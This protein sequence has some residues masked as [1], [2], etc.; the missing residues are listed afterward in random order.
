[1]LIDDKPFP[2][3]SRPHLLHL[4]KYY[5]MIGQTNHFYRMLLALCLM[6]L[7]LKSESGLFSWLTAGV[8]SF[9]PYHCVSLG[10]G[11]GGCVVEAS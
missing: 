7:T 3:A 5:Y 2:I 1:M 11:L 10:L 8:S 9:Q 4:P 6:R